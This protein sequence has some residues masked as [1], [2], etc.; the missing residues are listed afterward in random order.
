[1][2][3]LTW[4]THARGYE[5]FFNR[6]EQHSR[7]EALPPH[8]DATLD[9][10]MPTD[11]QGQGTWISVNSSGLTL[12]LL[13]R[14][15]ERELNI[16]T[17]ISRGRIIPAL[18]RANEL[19]EVYS[20]LSSLVG[21]SVPPFLL[22][23]IAHPHSPKVAAWTWDG[24]NLTQ[25]STRPPLVSSSVQLGHANHDRQALYQLMN[26]DA[27]SSADHFIYHQSHFPTQNATSVC[28]HRQDARTVSLSHILIQNNDIDF[29]YLP[30]SPCEHGTWHVTNMRYKQVS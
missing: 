17:P 4:L 18:I 25:A 15:P 9:C 8:Y 12:A 27:G 29:G 23:A 3:T 6:D 14:Y 7:E 2:C 1:M 21:P 22:F 26:L 20:W 16:K 28:M 30:G 5:I 11:P 10:L 19:R 24:Q 13:N